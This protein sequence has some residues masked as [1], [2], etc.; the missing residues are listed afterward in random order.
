[1]FCNYLQIL[2]FIQFKLWFLQIKIKMSNQ[3]EIDIHHE[4]KVFK[5]IDIIKSAPADVNLSE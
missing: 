5:V 2:I 3:N 1:M 4:K